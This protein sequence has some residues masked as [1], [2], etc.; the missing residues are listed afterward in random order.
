VR[1][2]LWYA[3]EEG[4]RG[5]PVRGE[6]G[7]HRCGGEAGAGRRRGGAWARGRGSVGAGNGAWLGALAGV[8]RRRR[9]LFQAASGG[10]EV[11]GG[12]GH[13]MSRMT[14]AGGLGSAGVTSGV[15]SGPTW[16]LPA[17]GRL[18]GPL[19]GVGSP[20]AGEAGPTTGG[21][22]RSSPVG[23]AGL[24]CARREE[25]IWGGDFG[26]KRRLWWVG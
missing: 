3:G 22:G 1:M 11:A 26:R 21:G 14:A 18:G 2:K 10:S 19:R 7:A 8:Y 4:S 13:R 16:L 17:R 12:Q 15:E 25:P 9:P 24:A 5:A 6:A 20:A 23:A